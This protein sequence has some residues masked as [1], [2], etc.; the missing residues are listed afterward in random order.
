MRRCITINSNLFWPP[1]LLNC[2]HEKPLRGL[3]ISVLAQQEIDGVALF[4]NRT[5]EV[6]PLA[7]HAD[8]GLVYSP[9]SPYWASRAATSLLE[10]GDVALYPSEDGCM[11]EV[12]TAF[13]HHLFQI[14]VAEL[15]GDVPA[16]A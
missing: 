13:G 7:S 9:R 15:V 6:L 16:D 14:A 3:N 8:V 5:V 1:L 4:T 12:D 11:S 10:L 2:S